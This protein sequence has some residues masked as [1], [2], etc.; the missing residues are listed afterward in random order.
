MFK[1]KEI[2]CGMLIPWGFSIHVPGDWR[3]E[4]KR[5]LVFCIR[6]PFYYRD[7]CYISNMECW[8]SAVLRI[9]FW[10]HCQ[11]VWVPDYEFGE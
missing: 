10:D 8:G 7:R 11:I 4:Q 1:I 5:R 3:E 2:T 6:L 9:R